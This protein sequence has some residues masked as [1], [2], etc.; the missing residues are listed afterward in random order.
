VREWIL[1]ASLGFIIAG[2]F[3]NRSILG[4]VPRDV[5]ETIQNPPVSLLDGENNAG[6]C[7]RVLIAGRINDNHLGNNGK[8]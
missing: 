7:L 4:N 6:T 2:Y 5:L 3:G 8:R 1:V